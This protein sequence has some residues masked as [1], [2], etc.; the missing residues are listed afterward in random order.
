MD[1]EASIFDST[2]R[3]L[4]RFVAVPGA[5]DGTFGLLVPAEVVPLPHGMPVRLLS[6][7][8]IAVVPVTDLQTFDSAAATE[9]IR[10]APVCS[11]F[12]I[13]AVAAS[14]PSA[15]LRIAAVLLPTAVPETLD[16][17]EPPEARR[18][19]AEGTPTLL[20]FA[21]APAVLL[22]PDEELVDAVLLLLE[23]RTTVA[24][25]VD[26]TAAAADA[27]GGAPS[28][29]FGNDRFSVV[30][31]AAFEVVPLPTPLFA[32]A[33]ELAIDVAPL[34]LLADNADDDVTVLCPPSVWSLPE[35]A[36][37]RLADVVANAA[38]AVAA[39][40]LVPLLLD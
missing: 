39:S 30:A 6:P 4:A 11:D 14:T 20:D 5:T 40:T 10:V 33:A 24:P 28:G 13:G 25:E 38:A 7:F 36:E 15:F 8:A 9:L 27:I 21:A 16:G 18:A 29:C 23:E 22:A 3:V 32:P 12:V 2:L 35:A 31:A 37:L 19:V 26:R 17:K 1:F 34:G